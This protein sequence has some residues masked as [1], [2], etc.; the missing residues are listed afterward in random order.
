MEPSTHETQVN[1][2]GT[3]EA[4]QSQYTIV[5][6]KEDV[7]SFEISGGGELPLFERTEYL[8]ETHHPDGLSPSVSLVRRRTHLSGASDL[9]QEQAQHSD[10]RRL[11]VKRKRGFD[12]STMERVDWVLLRAA[13][14]LS[15]QVDRWVPRRF[16]PII[17]GEESV[18]ETLLASKIRRYVLDAG[19]YTRRAIGTGTLILFIMMLF[20]VANMIPWRGYFAMDVIGMYTDERGRN[21]MNV[22]MPHYLDVDNDASDYLRAQYLVQYSFPHIN[23]KDLLRGYHEVELEYDRKANISFSILRDKLNETM[24]EGGYSC[25]CAAHLGVPL[26]V[27]QML[28]VKHTGLPNVRSLS[29]TTLYEP[30]LSMADKEVTTTAPVE[31]NL[32]YTPSIEDGNVYSNGPLKR[33]QTFPI[34]YPKRVALRYITERGFETIS[35][36]GYKA[37]C[38]VFCC[39]L[40]AKRKLF[41]RTKGGIILGDN[42]DSILGVF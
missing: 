40:S 38:V 36:S 31:S 32:Y 13:H 18:G 24:I 4:L 41:H 35:V 33:G 29:T 9:E 23:R 26:N 34:V 19:K 30:T 27:M 12:M 28:T 10:Y 42:D 20:M 5:S 17:S 7:T 14:F 1:I 37:A 3:E 15:K 16:N 11:R 39:E 22:E 21:I 25:L 8:T 6:S 2:S